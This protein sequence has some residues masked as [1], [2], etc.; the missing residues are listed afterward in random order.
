MK[1]VFDGQ[2]EL[3]DMLG[4]GMV[5]FVLRESDV[6]GKRN[7]HFNCVWKEDIMDVFSHVFSIFSV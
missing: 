7:L 6:A 4:A 2:G 3:M 5:V 1:I